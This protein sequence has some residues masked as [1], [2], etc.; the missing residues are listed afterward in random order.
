M[1]LGRARTGAQE[2]REDKDMDT[3]G[4]YREGKDRD[5]GG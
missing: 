3:A 1:R 2:A 4:G 5:T